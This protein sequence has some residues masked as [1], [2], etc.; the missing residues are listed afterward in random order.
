MDM[1]ISFLGSFSTFQSCT[2]PV[3]KKLGEKGYGCGPF[4]KV[5]VILTINMS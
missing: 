1:V 3:T 2:Y 4:P 5:D